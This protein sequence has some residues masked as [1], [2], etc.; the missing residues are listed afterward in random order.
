MKTQHSHNFFKKERKKGK[1]KKTDSQRERL[2]QGPPRHHSLWETSV[3]AKLC[4]TLP[5]IRSFSALVRGRVS[6]GVSWQTSRMPQ[7]CLPLGFLDLW[8][9]PHVFTT[10]NPSS[11]NQEVPQH[12]LADVGPSCLLQQHP[13]APSCPVRVIMA[14]PA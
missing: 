7:D 10:Q 14:R 4:L 13:E 1:K 2:L 3:L 11:G 6:L 9:S 5:V 8:S 12:L